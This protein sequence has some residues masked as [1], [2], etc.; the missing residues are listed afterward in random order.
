MD[1]IKVLEQTINVLEIMQKELKER[2]VKCK[3][4]R[5]LTRIGHRIFS[6]T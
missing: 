6:Y 3:D 2:E 4:G 1:S 5:M